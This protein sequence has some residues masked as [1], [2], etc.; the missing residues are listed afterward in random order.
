MTKLQSIISQIC[1]LPES[2]R[3]EL[4]DLL[5]IPIKSANDIYELT[6]E[7]LAELDERLKFVD[8]EPT[9]TVEEVF[10]KFL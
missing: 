10:Q 4:F 2:E 6:D 5:Q 1:E 3:S 9:R 8:I 7:E